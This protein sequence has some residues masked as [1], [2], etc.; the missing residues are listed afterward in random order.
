MGKKP[1]KDGKFFYRKVIRIPIFYGNFVIIFSN[2]EV[3]IKKAVHFKGELEEFAYTFTNFLCKGKE[4]IAVCF[5]FWT[6]EPVTLGT[7]VHEVN[8]AG[9]RLLQSRNVEPNFENDE[10]ESYVKSWMAEEVEKFMIECGLLS[11]PVKN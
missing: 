7:I 5:N 8:H 10:A 9:N 11:R 3:A 4:S 6:S 2:D 1:T